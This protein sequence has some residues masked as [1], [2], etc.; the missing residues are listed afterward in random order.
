MADS[1]VNSVSLVS[2]DTSGWVCAQPDAP[3]SA[4]ARIAATA[5]PVTPNLTLKTRAR[6]EANL[7]RTCFTRELPPPAD[8]AIKQT[9]PSNVMKK[10]DALEL[11]YELVNLRSNGGISGFISDVKPFDGP[12]LRIAVIPHYR[13]LRS[14]LK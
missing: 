1:T 10:M 13:I 9:L 6:I 11:V 12:P 14:V 4:I 8:I 3:D 2:R 7:C 5:T